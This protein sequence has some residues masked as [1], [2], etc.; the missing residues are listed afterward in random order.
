[1]YVALPHFTLFIHLLKLSFFPPILLLDEIG[2]PDLL[3]GWK[4]EK[5][6]IN[7]STLFWDLWN[8][9]SHEFPDPSLNR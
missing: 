1:M 5:L 8:K 3:L 2:K 6:A 4:D 7:V 9:G